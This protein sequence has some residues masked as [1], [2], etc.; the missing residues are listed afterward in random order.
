MV[1][2]VACEGSVRSGRYPVATLMVWAPL[3]VALLRF[4][5]Q[6]VQGFMRAGI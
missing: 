3:R 5:R 1:A 6:F 2:M 4:Q